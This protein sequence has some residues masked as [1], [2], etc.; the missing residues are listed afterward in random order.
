MHPLPT[1]HSASERADRTRARIL[2]AAV[3]HFGQNGLAGARTE[4]I[5]ESA[6][7]N[8]A[9]LYYYF[10]SKEALYAA[11]LESVFETIQDASIAVLRLDFSAGEKFL[12]IV[13]N[14]FDRVYSQVA[15]QS[16]I[17]QEMVRLH[18]GEENRM[19]R[20]A[21][22]FIKPM[23]FQLQNVLE[24]GIASGELVAVDPAQMR[25]ASIGANVFYFLSA[26]LTRLTLGI[27]PMERG[28]L[29]RRRTATIEFLGKALFTDRV[30]GAQ[31]ADRILQS[32]PMPWRDECEEHSA[33][34]DENKAGEAPSFSNSTHSRFA[35]KEERK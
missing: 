3:Q 18:M 15:L 34:D 17:Q 7:V 27:D 13:L 6:G 20:L 29:E 10:S 12:Q 24:E 4:Q 22:R 31:V 16:L 1:S 32:T 19:S 23:W 8:K 14:H 21:E 30:H 5:A 25:Y 11:A 26:P 28:E 35:A 9:L 2:R 33:T